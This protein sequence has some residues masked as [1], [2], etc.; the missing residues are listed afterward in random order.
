MKLMKNI[1]VLLCLAG[2]Q[3]CLKQ[4]ETLRFPALTE[5]NPLQLGHTLTYRLDSTF[6]GSSTTEFTI[7]SHLVKDSIADT[8]RDNTQRLAYIIY[9]FITDTL[10][11]NPWQSLYTYYTVAEEHTIEVMDD[12]NLRFI[13]MKQPVR[14]GFSWNGN[15]YIDTRSATSPYQ[16]MEGWNYTYSN[17]NQ[18]YTVLKG[19]IENTI[20]VLQVDETSPP[21]PFDPGNYQQRNYSIEVYAK[22]IGLIYKDFLHWTWQNTPPPARF[23]DDSY[24]I[25]LNLVEYK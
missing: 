7:S 20:T 6:L 18:P 24:G 21:G 3:S 16:Y 19:T 12:K 5:Y 4:S 1:L 10:A 22:G 9:R 11:A 14:D 2:M 23:T 15:S 17:I 25:R 13:K 8:T